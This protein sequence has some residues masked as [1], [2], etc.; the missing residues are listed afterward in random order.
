MSLK[1]GG[2]S[3]DVSHERGLLY[4]IPPKDVLLIL[5]LMQEGIMA[6]HPLPYCDAILY[7]NAILY[8]DAILY[9]RLNCICGQW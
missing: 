3:I 6:I 4:V 1:G 9:S 2:P 8:S 7:S 5:K